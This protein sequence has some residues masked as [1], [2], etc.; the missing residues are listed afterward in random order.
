[1]I[2][3]KYFLIICFLGLSSFIYGQADYGFTIKGG[4][5]FPVGDFSKYYSAGFGGFG[6]LFYNINQVKVGG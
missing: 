5:N 1:M 2:M 3:K 6:G 4:A